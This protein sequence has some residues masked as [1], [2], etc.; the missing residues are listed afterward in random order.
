MD[1]SCILYLSPQCSDSSS[2]PRLIFYLR[3]DYC[4]ILKWGLWIPVMHSR[5]SLRER[6]SYKPFIV[7]HYCWTL[8]PPHTLSLT[9]IYTHTQIYV[10]THTIT[11]M[12]VQIHIH[13]Q[14][15]LGFFFSTYKN[16]PTVLSHVERHSSSSQWWLHLRRLVYVWGYSNN[17][18]YGS[19]CLKE[20][21][22]ECSMVMG[23]Y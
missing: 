17:I 13:T 12:R 5:S 4:R 6:W 7:C 2:L 14:Y 8:T 20:T 23:V 9:H 18:G 19:S 10:F 21:V 11:H 22:H 15:S 3:M 16:Q 1:I